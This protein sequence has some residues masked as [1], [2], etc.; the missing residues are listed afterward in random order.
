MFKKILSDVCKLVCNWWIATVSDRSSFPF[1]ISAV[2]N[3]NLIALKLE[4]QNRTNRGSSQRACVLAR[5]I[6]FLSFQIVKTIVLFIYN[7]QSVEMFRW[8]EGVFFSTF[9]KRR[10]FGQF[11]DELR[12]SLFTR[13]FAVYFFAVFFL[14]FSS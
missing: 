9:L 4:C 12:S 1:A 3:R 2:R 5:S 6:S 10:N 14:V 7:M 8:T 13:L 11:F